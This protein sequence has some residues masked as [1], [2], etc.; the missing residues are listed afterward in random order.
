MSAAT[1][2]RARAAMNV[3]LWDLVRAEITR[4]RRTFTWG[5]IGTT[6][7][8]TVHTIIL[9]NASVSSGVVEELQWNGNALAWMHMY[10]GAFA[11]PLG[12][13]TG[14]MAQWR[15]QRWR[16]GGTAWRA[17]DPRRVVAAR[18]VVLSLSALACQV[19]L[20]A[21][22][23]A[24]ALIVGSGWGPW[25]RYLLFALYMWIVVTGACAWGMAAFRVA[26]VVAVGVAP[27]LGFVWSVAGAVQAERDDWWM[28]PWAWTARAALPLLGVHGNSVLLEE[29]S[30]VW[31]YP[32]APGLLLTSA[33]T[34][35]GAALALLAGPPG[36]VAP[37]ASRL[38]RLLPGKRTDDVRDDARYV[39]RTAPASPPRAASERRSTSAT[40]MA[41][42]PGPRS[43]VLAMAGVLPW[44]VWAVL[45]VLLLVLLGVL[46][47]AY[48]PGY[49]QSVLELM[50]VPVAA[51]VVG[52][53]VWGRLQPAWRVLITRRGAG[54]ILTSTAIL[55]ALFLLPVLV[56][57]WTVTVLGDTLTRTAPDLPALAGPVYGLMVMPAVAFMIAAVS[58]AV[59]LSTRIVVA[60]VLNV[61]LVVSGLLIGGNDVLAE[62][63]LWRI[64]PW[65]WITVAHQFPGRWLTIVV[66]SLLT[67]SV[68]MGLATL[69]SRRAAV[70]D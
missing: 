31:S 55:G 27:V 22:V 9:A 62:T 12:L 59:A 38:S 23:V 39:A 4:S 11:V 53:T 56:I 69:G 35:I 37:A 5:V 20:V 32:L 47:T 13:L 50:G 17:V 48:P 10:A 61:I 30:P 66:L 33:L 44:A 54:S 67:G 34:L 14:A 36:G 60:I 68:A 64:A 46:H 45:A 70:R 40:R 51:A 28:F 18:L 58:L 43:A 41:R 49:G 19:A 15:E 16:Q 2:V 29:D 42:V 26:R 1:P 25:D 52:I 21:P 57:S 3:S 24:H 8:F 7:I 63:W 65:G 6:L